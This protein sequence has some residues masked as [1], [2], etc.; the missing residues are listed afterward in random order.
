MEVIVSPG[1][2]EAGARIL[3]H[4]FTINWSL[5]LVRIVAPGSVHGAYPWVYGKPRLPGLLDNDKV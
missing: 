5:V 4:D 2:P 3:L 1:V